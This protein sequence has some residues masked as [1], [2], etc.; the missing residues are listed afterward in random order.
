[1][2]SFFRSISTKIF[3]IAAALLV[4]MVAASLAS[5]VLTR[6]VHRQLETL[7][8]SLYPLTVTV[9]DL[10][11]SLLA[12]RLEIAQRDAGRQGDDE[13]RR[14]ALR[15]SQEGDRLIAR[16]EALRAQ[17]VK[18]AQLEGNR[19]ELARLEALIDEIE[20]S[21][22]RLDALVLRQ[23][24]APIGSPL[25]AQVNA[26]TDEHADDLIGNVDAVSRE[27]E[28]FVEK[29]GRI[30]ARNEELAMQ[31]NLALIAVASLVG[32]LLAF[33][34]TR[35]LTRP[36]MRLRTGA[37][38]VQAGRLDEEVPVT[39]GDE[40]GDVTLAFN[41]MV[42]GLRAKERIKA[43]FGQYVDPRVVAELVEGG[44]ERISAGEKQVATVYFSDMAGFTSISERLAASSVV[45]LVNAYFSEMSQP[46]RERQGLIDKYIGDGIMAFWAPPFCEPSE[47]AALACAAALEQ[48]ERLEAFRLRVPDLVGLRRDAPHI[49]MRV[50][51]ATG[52]VIVGSVGSEIAKSFTV[53]GDTA[54]FGSRLEGANKAYGTRILIDETTRAMAGEAIEAREVD[55]IGVV[56]RD[57]PMRAFELAAM[58][59]TL[60]SGRRELFALYAVALAH[61]RAGAWDKAEA[62]FAKALALDADDGPST[63]MLDRTRLLRA[64]PPADW[65]GV[66]RLTSK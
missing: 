62:A 48:F 52:E 15:R 39:S 58:S 63:T 45:A 14:V 9:A 19:I 43:A 50:G 8:E 35:G 22:R 59:G 27:I 54:N 53:I 6:N 34:I 61:Y 46:I 1:M 11:A 17:G 2:A 33:L 56:G 29:G 10:R 31:A 3:G 40:I 44:A 64:A 5:A 23:C 49:S 51:L 60:D 37:Q 30:V 38:A 66:W 25:A 12:A 18:L 16:A 28:D 65:D 4:L 13:C 57:E 24:A 26:E 47:Q 55:M 42:A 41:E 7:S 21:H 32:L 20:R 36:I